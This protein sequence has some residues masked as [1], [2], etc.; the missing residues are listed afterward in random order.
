MPRL[1]VLPPRSSALEA[2]RAIESNDI[3]AVVVQEDGRVVG[4]VTDRDLA[5]RVVGKGL[6]PRTTLLRDIM[7]TPVVTLAPEESEA[8]AIRLM[9]HRG[10]RRIPLVEDGRLAGM[11]TLDD[12]VL[13][14]SVSLDDVAA[15]IES[16]IGER[17]PAPS[18][19]SPAARRRAAR[20]RATY[21]RLRN[22][23]KAEAALEQPEQADAALAI[24]LESLVKRLTLDDA[25]GFIAQL[26]SLIQP[27]LRALPPGP[28]KSI[29]RAAIESE[30]AGRLGMDRKRAAEVLAAVGANI[31]RCVSPGEVEELRSQLPEDL[32]AILPSRLGPKTPAH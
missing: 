31:A 2:A 11:V 1:V 20:A 12:L 23:I 27:R 13:S 30:L 22:Q 5:I 16:Q 10:V 32:R 19:R 24:V 21:G 3:G 8:D 4:M 25:E 6:D 26:P 28:D 9:C 18:R 7:T 29:T 17:G 15:V 14:E